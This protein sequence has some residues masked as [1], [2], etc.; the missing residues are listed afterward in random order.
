M[1][2]EIHLKSFEYK[3]TVPQIFKDLVPIID[4]EDLQNEFNYKLS[5]NEGSLRILQN[6]D[7]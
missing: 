2:V 3:S 7:N 6:K 1:S 5:F 4:I